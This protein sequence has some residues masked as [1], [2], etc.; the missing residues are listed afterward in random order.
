VK[1][2]GVILNIVSALTAFASVVAVLIAVLL[3]AS[4]DR[5]AANVLQQQYVMLL[6]LYHLGLALCGFSFARYLRSVV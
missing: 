2:F 5:L 3:A 6:A 1:T 4:V